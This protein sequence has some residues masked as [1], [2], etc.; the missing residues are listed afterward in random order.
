LGKREVFVIDSM[1][2]PVCKRVRAWRCRK[3]RGKVYCGYCAAK[4]EKFFGWRLHLVCTAR[5]VPVAFEVLPASLHD[6]TPLHE[7]AYSLPEGANLFGDK[8]Y[9]SADDTLTILEESG[10]RLV[11]PK[12]TNMAPNRWADDYDLTLYRKCIETVYSQ[13]EA[14]GLQR[15]HARTNTGFDLKVWASLLALAFTNILN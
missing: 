2:M 7:L 10:V 13:C 14:M 12:R 4:R 8:G 11:T 9:L 5:G 1:P 6:L 15:L 3:V